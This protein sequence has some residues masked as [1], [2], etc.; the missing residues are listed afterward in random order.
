M[1]LI[2]HTTPE[3]TVVVY[4]SCAI[5]LLQRES[6]K[7]EFSISSL[8]TGHNYK[9]LHRLHLENALGQEV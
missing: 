2:S 4:A 5:H 9:L 8:N 3:S 7:D 1:N 6:L